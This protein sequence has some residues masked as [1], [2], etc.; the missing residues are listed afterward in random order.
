MR[1]VDSFAAT[2]FEAHALV[3]LGFRAQARSTPGYIPTPLCGSGAAESETTSCRERHSRQAARCFCVR[4]CEVA[5][6]ICFPSGLNDFENE[7]R[8]SLLAE[9]ATVLTGASRPPPKALRKR[10]RVTTG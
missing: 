3:N 7:L 10:M 9:F 6:S 5:V 8:R 4:A 1:Q 2:R